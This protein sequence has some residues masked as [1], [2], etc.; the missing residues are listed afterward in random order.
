[1]VCLVVVRI[2]CRLCVGV[3][4]LAFVVLVSGL[5]VLLVLLGFWFM[6][7]VVIRCCIM[8]VSSGVWGL[9]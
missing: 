4:W 5:L 8:C 3:Y 9:V 1:M 6:V 7:A 2:V